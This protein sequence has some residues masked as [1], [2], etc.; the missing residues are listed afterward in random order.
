MEHKE[1]NNTASKT[2]WLT[3]TD[4]EYHRATQYHLWDYCDA[5]Y[6]PEEGEYLVEGPH[7]RFYTTAFLLGLTVY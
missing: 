3:L 4:E 2:A 5:S 6:N 1:S 7:T